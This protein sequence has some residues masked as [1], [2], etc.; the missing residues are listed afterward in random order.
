MGVQLIPSDSQTA[1]VITLADSSA[2]VY[3]DDGIEVRSSD[4]AAVQLDDAKHA[5]EH[6]ADTNKPRELLPNKHASRS[7]RAA[8]CCSCR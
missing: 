1:G 7:G 8:H 4:V 6:G 2:I 3:G 5:V